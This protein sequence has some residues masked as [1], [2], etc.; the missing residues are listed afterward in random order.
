[1]LGKAKNGASKIDTL[2]TVLSELLTSMSTKS[3]SPGVVMSFVDMVSL[4]SIAN[5]FDISDQSAVQSVLA[6]I[7]GLKASGSEKP[8]EALQQ[9]CDMLQQ[10][11]TK[12][13]RNQVVSST[14]IVLSDGQG[15]YDLDK[16]LPHYNAIVQSRPVTLYGV[17]FGEDVE[18]AKLTETAMHT[19]GRFCF[20]DAGSDIKFIFEDLVSRAQA[21]VCS[22]KM[23]IA[24]GQHVSTLRLHTEF[25]PFQKDARLM[26]KEQ[27]DLGN[28][29]VGSETNILL[30]A[31]LATCT[32][33]TKQ[34]I[35]TVKVQFNNS[36]GK[37]QMA[38]VDVFV[39]RIQ[40][41]P[42]VPDVPSSPE[43]TTS[44]PVQPP[45]N[46]KSNGQ[47]LRQLACE[48][49]RCTVKGAKTDTAIVER[50]KRV[51]GDI[52]SLAPIQQE[53][54]A[55]LDKVKEAKPQVL[56]NLADQLKHPDGME[57]FLRQA[58]RK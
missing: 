51:I 4:N 30:R 18:A 12:K 39:R 21:V 10:C 9:M 40:A 47:V 13:R 3:A 58:A 25:P 48:I 46:A 5:W 32:S 28:A 27:F 54:N 20:G 11:G 24:P 44:N 43:F 42:G 23:T 36:A 14:C 31:E 33:E 45:K 34:H 55:V 17:G 8:N 49:V 37:T 53:M 2:K 52:P 15:G 29:S 57:G 7:G 35:A 19:G 6:S 22:R 50:A 1:M 16:F 56:A 41:T 38:G 26:G